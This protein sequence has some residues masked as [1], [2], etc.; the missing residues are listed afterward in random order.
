MLRWAGRSLE[1]VRGFA[2]SLAEAVAEGEFSV[3]APERADEIGRLADAMLTGGSSS[4]R[5]TGQYQMRIAGAAARGMLVGAA[6]EK[7]GVPASEIVTRDSTLIHEASGRSAPYAEFAALAAEHGRAPVLFATG[8]VG[9]SVTH[10]LALL[11]IGALFAVTL[12][13]VV[14][15]VMVPVQPRVWSI[16][17]A[18]FANSPGLRYPT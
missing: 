5:T 11:F 15:A 16:V 1:L 3:R 6:A 18:A 17:V 14:A 9:G 7:W 12:L 13:Y 4:I 8:V 10:P 2:S